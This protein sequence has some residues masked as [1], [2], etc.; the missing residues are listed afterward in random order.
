MKKKLSTT[1]Y[2]RSVTKEKSFQTKPEVRREIINVY[3][4]KNEENVL[5][6]K[7]I[8]QKIR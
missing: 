7:G 1:A 5:V 4:E 8:A 3:H 2:A 6:K